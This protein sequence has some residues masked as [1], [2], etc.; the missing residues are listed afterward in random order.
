VTIS[1][2]VPNIR[3][4]RP[5]ETRDLFVDLLGFELAMDMV[6]VVTVASPTN[7]GPLPRS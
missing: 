6:W 5:V 1:R 7:L 2:A 3:S 4:E